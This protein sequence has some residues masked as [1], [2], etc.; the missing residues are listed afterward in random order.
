MATLADAGDALVTKELLIEVSA[1]RM[2]A[3]TGR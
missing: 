1:V 2:K 3:K